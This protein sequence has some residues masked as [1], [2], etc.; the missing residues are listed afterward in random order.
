MRD[1]TRLMLDIETL[2]TEPGC[3]IVS[4]GACYFDESG[5]GD[6]FLREVSLSSC[7]AAGL[8]IDHDTLAWWG[9]QPLSV[10]ESLWRGR[11]LAT[12]LRV[13]SDFAE[14]A[15]EVWAKPPR[16]DCEILAAA[17]ETTGVDGPPWEH[18]QTR[19]V[20]AL[21]AL[22]IDPDTPDIGTDHDALD[23][24]R[25]QAVRIRAILSE[26]SEDA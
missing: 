12:V 26:V 4:V 25:E 14:D 13:F 20:R 10:R 7:G 18:W 15:T 11:P 1:I 2:G 22:P 21:K 23:D 6:T 16:F 3:A 17:Y 24:A 5:V 8:D 19:D 9:D